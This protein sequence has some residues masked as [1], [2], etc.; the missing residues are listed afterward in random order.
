MKYSS[1]KDIDQLVRSLVRKGWLYWRGR[2]HGR[3]QAPF[4]MTT[5]TV[6]VSPSDTHA[7]QNFRRDVERLLQSGMRST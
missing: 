2:K 7:F 4:G 6:P 3:L 1:Q 5:L